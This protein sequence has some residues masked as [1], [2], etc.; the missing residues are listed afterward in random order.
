MN[1]QLLRSLKFKWQ[2]SLTVVTIIAIGLH[3]IIQY[4]SPH[5]FMLKNSADNN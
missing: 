3:F 2:F 4:L 5:F 1:F